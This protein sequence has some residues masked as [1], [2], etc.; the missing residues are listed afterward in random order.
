MDNPFDELSPAKNLEYGNQDSSEPS[1]RTIRR[2]RTDQKLRI[3]IVFIVLLGS[4]LLL[5]FL[6]SSIVSGSSDSA[7]N[8]NQQPPQ[9]STS[10]SP[11]PRESEPEPAEATPT[12]TVTVTETESPSEIFADSGSDIAAIVG[13]NS[14]NVDS[15][16]LD[17]RFT[18]CYEAISSGYGD[19][20]NGINPEYEWYD[21]RDRDGV[22]CER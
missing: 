13:N 6:L 3:A 18:Y 17:P 2:N 9:V 20:V 22:V 21:D 14:N 11:L 12:V 1:R 4:G 19:Y 5:G 15:K 10:P 7:L 16:G 8:E